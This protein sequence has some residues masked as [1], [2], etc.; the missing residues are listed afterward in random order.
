MLVAPVTVKD[1][2]AVPPPSGRAAG[3][4]VKLVMIGT[5]GSA[6]P[7]GDPPADPPSGDPPPVDPP[8]GDARPADPPSGDPPPEDP[9][10][11]D[12]TVPG[13]GEESDWPQAQS[14]VNR[15]R[16]NSIHGRDT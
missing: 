13:S 14:A 1:N 12:P 10:S 3:V 8:S 4:A 16:T 11:G 6:P 7:S 15:A 9:P 2:V 5:A